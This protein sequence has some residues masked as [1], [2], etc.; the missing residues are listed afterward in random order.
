M[1]VPALQP[2]LLLRNEAAMSLYRIRKIIGTEVGKQLS[3]AVETAWNYLVI[4]FPVLWPGIA[5]DRIA[6]MN[7][8]ELVLPITV[9]TVQYESIGMH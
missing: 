3:L 6:D 1:T 5:H 8:S 2:N 4:T 9:V 7:T